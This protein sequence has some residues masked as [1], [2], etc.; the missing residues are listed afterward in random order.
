MSSGTCT[1]LEFN[2]KTFCAIT[3]TRCYEL[4]RFKNEKL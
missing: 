2:H 4:V 3:Y 1:M